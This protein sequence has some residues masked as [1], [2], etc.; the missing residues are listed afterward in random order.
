MYENI[1]NDYL[2]VRGLKAF[3][4]KFFVV[5]KNYGLF[6]MCHI[7]HLLINYIFDAAETHNY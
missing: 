3:F 1:N 6:S 7:T 2:W 4:M 5:V